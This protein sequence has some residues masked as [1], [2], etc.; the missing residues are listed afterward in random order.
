MI[1]HDSKKMTTATRY[2]L[3]STDH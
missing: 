3:Q 1:N 2:F